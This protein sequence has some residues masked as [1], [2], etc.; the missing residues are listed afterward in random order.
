MARAATDQLIVAAAPRCG[1]TRAAAC[2]VP[3]SGRSPTTTTSPPTTGTPTAT[4]TSHNVWRLHRGNKL[5]L[6]SLKIFAA[7]VTR[8]VRNRY[9]CDCMVHLSFLIISILLGQIVADVPKNVEPQC[10]LLN[11]VR[12]TLTAYLNSSRA[13]DKDSSILSRRSNASSLKYFSVCVWIS[14]TVELLMFFFLFFGL[15]NSW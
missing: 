9:I 10:D 12:R 2:T 6:L 14:T 4:T 5:L 13:K 15:L 1:W 3:S 8:H 7:K 11:P